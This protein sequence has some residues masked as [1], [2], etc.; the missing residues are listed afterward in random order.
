MGNRGTQIL[1][2]GAQQAARGSLARWGL[3][4]GAGGVG[5]TIVDQRLLEGQL[6]KLATGEESITDWVANL[7]EILGGGAAEAGPYATTIGIAS[8]F[9]NAGYIANA[10]LGGT[11]GH[12]LVR[13]GDRIKDIANN[14]I[15]G[16]PEALE[17]MQQAAAEEEAAAREA[18]AVD[19]ERAA[20]SSI[21][22]DFNTH[23]GDREVTQIADFNERFAQEFTDNL[24][25]YGDDNFA[26]AT[27]AIGEID[28]TMIDDFVGFINAPD[29][30]AAFQSMAPSQATETINGLRTA[31]ETDR[32]RFSF[33]RAPAPGSGSIN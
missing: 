23:G 25:E 17:A 18:S 19:P 16:T 33:D 13:V 31:L 21:T 14:G 20:Q 11:W 6:F 27:Q 1:T 3:A 12:A 24:A 9:R 8:F 2:S 30:M 22:I 4:A 5:L 7:N 15:P 26:A 32:E 29:V 28:P 10:F